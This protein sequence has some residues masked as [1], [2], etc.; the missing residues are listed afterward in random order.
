MTNEPENHD[1]DEVP[2]DASGMIEG[3]RAGGYSLATAIADIID[4]SITASCRNVWL[5]MEWTGDDSWISITDDGDGMKDDE[6]KQ[7]MRLASTHPLEERRPDDLGRFGLGL[8]TASFSQARRLTVL[9]KVVGSEAA[10]RRWDLDH[11][12][13]PD[14]TGWQLLRTAHEDTGDR[15]DELKR[16]GLESGTVVLLEELDRVVR[17]AGGDTKDDSSEKHWVNQV[18]R[19]R[20][21]LGMVFHRFL[22][23]RGACRLTISINGSRVEP[24]DPFCEAHPATQREAEDCNDRLGSKVLFKGYILPHRDRFD[25]KDPEKGR[26]LHQAAAGPNGW[27]AHQGFY[28]YRNDRLIIPGDWLG[29]GPGQNGWKKEEHFKLARIR[30]DIPNSMDTEWQIDVKKSAAAAPPPLR[31]WLTSLAKTVRDKAKKVYAHRGVQVPL[32]HNGNAEARALNQPNP[33]ETLTR[34]DGTF[35]YRVSRKHTLYKALLSAIEGESRDRM[36]TFLRLVEETVPVQRIWID[37]AEHEEA[38]AKPFDGEQDKQLRRHIET[39]HRAL[40]STG[41][42]EE[43]AW[44]VVSNFPAFQTEKAAAIIG[45]LR[46]NA[47]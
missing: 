32:N 31:S 17:R 8:K 10:L 24:W 15:I 41:N 5:R 16:L 2:P 25:P 21:H 47:E 40:C 18:E 19:V 3:L 35:S 9:S 23:R 42:N 12:A 36:E 11:L 13:R 34:T 20:Q 45:Q 33:W 30:V 37:A 46:E 28:L 26:K 4:N 1:F 27:N 7:A 6:L 39:C 14:V 22:E 38:Y 29:L 44:R 43:S